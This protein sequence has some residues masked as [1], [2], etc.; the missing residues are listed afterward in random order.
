MATVWRA[1]DSRL[2]RPVAVKILDERLLD[3]VNAVARFHIEAQALAALDHPRIVTVHDMGT[4]D[5]GATL[6]FLVMEL[7]PGP[8]LAAVARQLPWQAAVSLGADVADALVAAHAH[9]IVHRDV[10]AANVLVTPMG[11]KLIDFGI[12]AVSGDND[13]AEDG[14]LLG[15]PA[16]LAP[17]RVDG[18]PVTPAID[19]YALGVLLYLLLTGHSP[20][21]G[22]GSNQ[23]GPPLGPRPAP[24]A[25]KVAGLPSSVAET[26]LRCLDNDPKGRPSAGEVAAVLRAAEA[27]R[28]APVTAIVAVPEDITTRPLMTFTGPSE[29]KALRR[30]HRHRSRRR[31]ALIGAA[32]T[33]F[34]V[35]A[36]LLTVWTPA[37]VISPQALEP[38]VPVAAGIT[39][40]ATYQVVDA[41][42]AMVTLTNDDDQTVA[43]GWRLRVA[44]GQ[45]HEPDGTIVT[46]PPGSVALPAGG[47]I[48]LPL[49]GEDLANNLTP[50]TFWLNRRICAATVISLPDQPAATSPSDPP[51]RQ[52]KGGPKS[53]PPK[54]VAL[55]L[56]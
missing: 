47:S 30:Q 38:P 48:Q 3:D 35:L 52:G 19:I 13:T 25:P 24:A 9:G 54:H 11:A 17:E 12:C 44:F 8:P 33:T 34:L 45:R 20:W 7:V 16:Y 1:R 5:R 14:K 42:A 15:T 18:A 51:V 53:K 55:R 28:P 22:P 49:A 27:G 21:R 40:H 6:P 56:R 26:C 10:T 32:L 23:D 46:S 50:V 37:P 41:A 31:G 39:C 4:A 2:G 36:W 43:P 29:V